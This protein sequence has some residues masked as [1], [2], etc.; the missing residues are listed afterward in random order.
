MCG[1]IDTSEKWY[2]TAQLDAARE[3]ASG[4][5]MAMLNGELDK[6]FGNFVRSTGSNKFVKI[7]YKPGKTLTK[8]AKY[9]IICCIFVRS[10]KQCGS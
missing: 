5:V 1:H 7:T 3:R 10:W 4:Y 9:D 6:M 8:G 2:T